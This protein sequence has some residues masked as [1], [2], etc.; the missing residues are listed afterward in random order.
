MNE[1]W[2]I[3]G[4]VTSGTPTGIIS[5]PFDAA[6]TLDREYVVGPLRLL[7]GGRPLIEYFRTEPTSLSGITTVESRPLIVGGTGQPSRFEHQNFR[8]LHRLVCLLSLAWMEPWQVRSGPASADLPREIPESW[9]PPHQS[10]NAHGPR[11]ADQPES[12]PDFVSE[13]WAALASQECQSMATMW[14]QGFLVRGLHPSLAHLAFAAVIEA[15]GK[16]AWA[17]SG[18]VAPD[19][20][21]SKRFA[22]VV[23]LIAN[24]D[25]RTVLREL[26]Y[27]RRS[28]SVHDA[29]AHAGEEVFGALYDF[30]P[31]GTGR[32]VY[33]DPRAQFGLRVVGTMQ[34]VAAGVI[35]AVIAHA[36]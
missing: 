23:E 27:R 9:M 24:E 17:R 21:P 28:A 14:H 32:T 26:A 4:P 36:R 13:A 35:K 31:A 18:G 34:R 30:P 25:D 15:A 12:L 11:L 22:G 16:S 10:L 6:R 2:A 33:D 5:D 29:E 1:W 3:V 19:A 8:D 20:G 7:P